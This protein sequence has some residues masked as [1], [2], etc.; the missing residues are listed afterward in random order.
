MNDD[1]I[2][3]NNIPGMYT[4]DTLDAILK[5]LGKEFRKLN[6]NK[7]PAEIILVGGAAVVANYG[8]RDRTSDIDALIQ[9][10]SAMS[11]AIDRVGDRNNMGK[12]W[13][14]QDF[15]K[16]D[17]FSPK[18]V[19]YSKPYRT[20]S[21]IMHVRTLP[22]EYIVAMKLASLRAYKYD[23]SDVIGIINE[24]K[25]TRPR[26]EQAVTDLYG[27]ME[28]LKTASTAKRLL[29]DI[30]NAPKD[31][32][33]LYQAYRKDEADNRKILK[34]LDQDYP[35]LLNTAN[36]NDVL[37]AARKKLAE[38]NSGRSDTTEKNK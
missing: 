1:K 16:T 11:M 38:K 2:T 13:L 4:K 34:Q 19:L 36:I 30:Y 18:I 28:T 22:A 35:E 7:T 33:A 37:A 5:E 14:N 27:S 6:G 12:G 15:K 29:D 21:N 32:E 10:S 8:F 9:A 24:S 31:L 26:V 20:F 23:F 25:L 3:N 17:S